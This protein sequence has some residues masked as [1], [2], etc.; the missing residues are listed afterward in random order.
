MIPSSTVRSPKA[1]AH[2]AGA[3]YV[4]L[5]PTGVMG[6]LY[7]QLAVLVPGDAAAT[8]DKLVAAQGMVRLSAASGLVAQLIN[9]AL[10]LLLYVLLKPANRVHAALMVIFSLLAVPIAFVAEIGKLAALDLAGAADAMSA[11]PTEQVQDQ[12]MALLAFHGH[13]ITVASVFWGL[14]LFPMGWCAY[15]SGYIPRVIGVLLMIGCFGYLIDAFRV[16]LLPRWELTLA[17]YL[18]WGEVA[19]A[20]WLLIRGVNA[21][22]WHKAARAATHR[23]E[24][25]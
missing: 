13:G 5:I 17:E 19:M 1:L 7:L 8:F 3:L 10:V 25:A 14:W 2:I 23:A 12:A 6:I 20:L 4:A 15:R 16:I 21:D 22:Q 18:F 24:Q 9:I 11:L